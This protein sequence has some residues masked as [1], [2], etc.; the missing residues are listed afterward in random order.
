MTRPLAVSYFTPFCLLALQ[1]RAVFM[2]ISA[3]PGDRRLCYLLP[4]DTEGV[5]QPCFASVFSFTDKNNIIY[6]LRL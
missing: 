1:G 5:T 3:E 2:M 6:L 4:Y